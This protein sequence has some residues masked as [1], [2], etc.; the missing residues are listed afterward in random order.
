MK[1]LIL[2]QNKFCTKVRKYVLNLV[3]I[4]KLSTTN[5]SFK[6]ERKE[7]SR[8]TEQARESKQASNTPSWSLLQFL[9][10]DSCPC[11]P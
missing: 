10:P 9:P 5:M 2:Y 3:T 7:A 4:K 6:K 11:F 1:T 8:Q